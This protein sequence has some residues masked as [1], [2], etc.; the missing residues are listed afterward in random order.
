MANLL[1]AKTPLEQVEQR[2]NDLPAGLENYFRH[3]L[4]Q[5][6]DRGQRKAVTQILR[7]V[8]IAVRP[9]KVNELAEA[10]RTLAS[11]SSE[12]LT[13][14]EKSSK[15]ELDQAVKDP[16][17]YIK[18]CSPLLQIHSD[19]VYFAND[20]A[21]QFLFGNHPPPLN[22]FQIDRFE[23]HC[24]TA[25]FCIEYIKSSPL[26]TR[27]IATDDGIFHQWPGLQ[28]AT[29]HW[30]EHAR[31]SGHMGKLLVDAAAFMLDEKSKL[32]QNWWQTYVSY[33]SADL[34]LHKDEKKLYDNMSSREKNVQ[35]ELDKAI[36]PPLHMCSRLG[37]VEWVRYLLGK[38]ENPKKKKAALDAMDINGIRPLT[39]AAMENHLDVAKVLLA[40]NADPNTMSA[41]Q[42]KGGSS[43]AAVRKMKSYA[44]EWTDHDGIWTGD[45][46]ILYRAVFRG[47][48]DM[49]QLLLDHGADP[50]A[51]GWSDFST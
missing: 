50:D 23:S 24:R 41:L 25:Q 14:Y 2:L 4:Q 40:E 22:E 37:L 15:L 28:Y 34:T 19:Y 30:C 47:H 12:Q 39:W 26:K 8:A 13:D 20:S 35:R 21:R 16:Q 3:I 31:N 10:M 38:I 45:H 46:T 44:R 48:V 1:A 6:H 51:L 33:H 49:V 29:V 5:I 17:G 9:L 32:R 42:P 27:S 7:L 11:A 18:H 36:P 43:Y